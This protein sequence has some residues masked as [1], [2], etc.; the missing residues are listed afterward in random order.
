MV[1]KA[2]SIFPE[3]IKIKKEDGEE[4]LLK[5]TYERRPLSCD[6]CKVFGHSLELYKNNP[7]PVE[8]TKEKRVWVPIRKESPQNRPQRVTRSNENYYV[9][10][11]LEM[12]AINMSPISV[13]INDVYSLENAQISPVDRLQVGLVS[14]VLS[15]IF[16]KNLVATDND[17]HPEKF[18]EDNKD[19]EY[20]DDNFEDA[21]DSIGIHAI[22]KSRDKKG[23]GRNKK[24]APSLGFTL[25]A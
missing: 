8:T 5:V 9:P 14:V 10:K 18:A 24:N 16:S 2:G 13:L 25:L 22:A 20:S 19:G 6:L 1:F 3:V 11:N 23:K 7:I 12:S 17:T 4:S 21:K 15:N